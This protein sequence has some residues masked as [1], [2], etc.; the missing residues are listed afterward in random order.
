MKKLSDA[1]IYT[2]RRLQ[3]ST[4]YSM[5]GD[6]KKGMERRS[7]GDY[8]NAPSIPVLYRLGLVEFVGGGNRSP[9]HWYTVDLTLKGRELLPTLRT[10]NE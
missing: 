3:N 4:S 9:T 8:V 6:G 7:F 10:S 5:Q 1:Q 2:M